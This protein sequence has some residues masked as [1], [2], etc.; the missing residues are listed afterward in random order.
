MPEPSPTLGTHN[1]DAVS[2]G[3][4]NA[5]IHTQPCRSDRLLAERHE[6]CIEGRPEG[7][8]LKSRSW[9][10]SLSLVCAAMALLS[11]SEAYAQNIDK[12]KISAGGF[13]IIKYSSTMSLTSASVGLG[14]AFSPEDTLGWEG[15]Q[16]VFRL[17][18]R[19]R[20]TDK[21]ALSM[22]WYNISSDGERAIQ[23]DIEWLGRDGSPITIP[24][25]ASVTSSLDYDILKLA[26]LWS[27]YHTDK[28][29]LSVG[30]G[31]H[32]TDVVVDLEATVINNS[33]AASK[34]DSL[35]P[36]PVVSF[37]LGY[38]VTP[39]LNWFMQAEV[40]SISAGGWDGTYSDLQ[41]AIEYRALQ[42]LGFGIGLGSSSLKVAEETNKS[43]F[44]FDNRISGI[45]LF[46]SGYF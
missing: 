18:G 5:G 35:V 39:K 4:R 31:V 46:V 6:R 10:I 25:G 21:H 20:I 24:V 14:V 22:S 30:A 3:V 15:E 16:T 38:D 13:S 44:D 2:V 29:E 19:Y 27:F 11:F 1:C 28:V 8:D 12:L 17:D 42:H 40:F 36:L 43:R 37:R 32:L 45:N 7:A 23:K 9:Q 26:Y 41:L 34:A 33:V